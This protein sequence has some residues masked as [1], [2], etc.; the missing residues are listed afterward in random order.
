MATLGLAM[1]ARGT[2]LATIGPLGFSASTLHSSSGQIASG[3]LRLEIKMGD[4]GKRYLRCVMNDKR[5]MYS[6]RFISS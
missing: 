5:V 3:W 1:S 4:E 2:K 6:W